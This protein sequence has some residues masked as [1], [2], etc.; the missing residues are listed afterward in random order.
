MPIDR[1]EVRATLED[2]LGPEAFAARHARG[3]TLSLDEVVTLAAT[4]AATV[5]E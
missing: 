2:A 1:T 4:T 3:E 5:C